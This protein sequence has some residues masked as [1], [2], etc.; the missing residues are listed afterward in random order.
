MDG[1]ISPRLQGD[2][3]ERA[4]A[5]WL[6]NQPRTSVFIP[7]GHSP[8]TDLVAEM[9][10]RLIRVQVKTSTVLINNG[11]Y[12]VSLATRGGNRSWNGLVKRFSST[13]CEYLFVLV[14]DG[15]QWFIPSTVVDGGS[16][17]VVGGPK[18]A[19]HEVE[20]GRPF[21]PVRTA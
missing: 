9:D 11:R 7:F 2:I 13:R 15:R 16:Q 3:G 14:A 1:R 20:A 10:G 18:Y 12:Q 5:V 21:E 19:D 6:L 4:A 8:D 17:I